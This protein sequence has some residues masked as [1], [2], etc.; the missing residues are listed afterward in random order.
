MYYRSKANKKSTLFLV[1]AHVASDL[2]VGIYLFI[3]LFI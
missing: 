3:Y 2:H 1:S